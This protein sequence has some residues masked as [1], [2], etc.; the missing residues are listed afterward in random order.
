MSY[1]MTETLKGAYLLSQIEGYLISFLILEIFSYSN[2][3]DVYL[4]EFNVLSSPFY[5][6]YQDSVTSIF[7][8][9]LYFNLIFV[10][11]FLV[12]GMFM[13]LSEREISG[14]K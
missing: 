6:I 3:F 1:E 8:L 10:Y 14:F 7:F 5:R 4:L 12:L 13:R 9:F 11:A 2:I